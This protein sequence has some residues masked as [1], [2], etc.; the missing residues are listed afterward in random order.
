MGLNSTRWLAENEADAIILE[1]GRRGYNIDALLEVD[2]VHSATLGDVNTFDL[3]GSLVAK[4]A[5]E[6]PLLH[7]LGGG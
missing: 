1:L 4:N 2:K 3:L 6:S 5:L 7:R